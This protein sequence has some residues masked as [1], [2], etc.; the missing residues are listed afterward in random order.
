MKTFYVS[1][2]YSCIIA[3]IMRQATN[4]HHLKRKYFFLDPEATD[5][6][7]IWKTKLKDINQCSTPLKWN[8]VDVWKCKWL[9]DLEIR[10]S[11]NFLRL[12]LLK[13]ESQRIR[14]DCWGMHFEFSKETSGKENLRKTKENK[15]KEV[16]KKIWNG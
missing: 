14:Q 12:N 1:N 9:I 2:M 8:F 5:M 10:S 13:K 7:K 16:S 15:K 6:D 4:K 11:N 3:W